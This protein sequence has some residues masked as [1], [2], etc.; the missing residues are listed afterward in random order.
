MNE[1]TNYLDTFTNSR[2]IES[3]LKEAL[4]GSAMHLDKPPAKTVGEALERLQDLITEYSEKSWFID[5]GFLPD[6]ERLNEQIVST[7]TL[8]HVRTFLAVLKQQETAYKPNGITLCSDAQWKFL[9]SRGYKSER[10][11]KENVG[12]IIASLKK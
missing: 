11:T 2:F 3:V 12:R 7:E 5:L 8:E 4:Q 9:Q 1:H 6:L 10:P